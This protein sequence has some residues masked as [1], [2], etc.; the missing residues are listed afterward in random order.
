M[1]W[2]VRLSQGR[3]NQIGQSMGGGGGG[4]VLGAGIGQIPTITTAAATVS[5]SSPPIS[6]RTNDFII[7]NNNIDSDPDLL[8]DDNSEPI[9]TISHRFLSPQQ[10]SQPPP[11]KRS[12]VQALLNSA[13]LTSTTTSN[14][15]NSGN[16]N[17]I[18]MFMDSG[19]STI[20][21]PAAGIHNF[22]MIAISKFKS[23]VILINFLSVHI[24]FY[25]FFPAAAAAA[26][27]LV[28]FSHHSICF[29]F[30]LA[31]AVITKH[32]HTHTHRRS[33]T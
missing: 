12:L 11:R 21:P 3:Q 22:G 32:F 13:N 9:D 20:L 29:Y 14:Q 28:A 24:L 27:I 4:G 8:I 33:F 26:H 16:I 17:S 30:G 19:S 2:S 10:P 18:K 5:S 15:D 7:N 31:L 6:I 1:F 25:R 23:N